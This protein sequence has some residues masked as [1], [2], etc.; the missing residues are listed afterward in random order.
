MYLVTNENKKFILDYKL[1]DLNS[2]L[3]TTEFY[4]VNRTFIININTIKDVIVYSNNRLKVTPKVRVEKEII[5]SRE[6]VSSFKKWFEGN[7]LNKKNTN[8]FN[9]KAVYLI[10]AVKI[11]FNHDYAIGTYA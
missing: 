5:V 1:E 8:F 7:Q 10:F 2:V 9:R 3:S 11:Q 6:K 4:R